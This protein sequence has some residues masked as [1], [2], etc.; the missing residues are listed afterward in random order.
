MEIDIPQDFSQMTGI[1]KPA[2]VSMEE[3]V[4]SMTWEVANE[5]PIALKFKVGSGI[6]NIGNNCYMNSVV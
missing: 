6:A 5:S 4:N 1:G 2:D 3:V